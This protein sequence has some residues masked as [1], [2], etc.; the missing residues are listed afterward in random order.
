MKDTKQILSRLLDGAVKDQR[1]KIQAAYNDIQRQ[2]DKVKEGVSVLQSI[3]NAPSTV[4][5]WTCK[6]FTL[7]LSNCDV[8]D[9]VDVPGIDLPDLGISDKLKAMMKQ[10][11]PDLDLLDIDM[12]GIGSYVS[13]PRLR[14]TFQS[15]NVTNVRVW[16]L[17]Q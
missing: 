13:W 8:P 2:A 7:G 12:E 15:C 4:G 3:A 6:V 17:D 16:G 1:E 10:M 14:M 11:A 5:H 9:I